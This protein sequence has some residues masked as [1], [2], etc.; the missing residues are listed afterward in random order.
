M[1]EESARL[2]LPYIAAS[3][4]QKHVTHNEALTLL[5]TLCQASV[6]DKDLTTPPGS[7]AE[8]DCYIV[9]A[10]GTG[11]WTGW[12]NRVVRYIDGEWRSYLPGAGSG[13][14]WLVYVQDEASLY[15]FSGSA[16]TLFASSAQP[17]DADL[18]AIAGLSPSNDDIIQRKAGAWTNRTLAQLKTDLTLT[19]GDVG[20][21]NVDNTSDINKP[22]S[23]AQSGA[24]VASHRRI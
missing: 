14:G 20:L 10:T 23:T 4:A 2:R 18:T 12:D 6:I 9:A 17:L 24:I 3:Q 5:D 19:K 13:E 8:G 11:A 21:G 15:V 22:V 16:W 1:S 7:P